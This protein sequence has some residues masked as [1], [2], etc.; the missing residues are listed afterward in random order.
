LSRAVTAR[1]AAL[2]SGLPLGWLWPLSI[3]LDVLHDPAPMKPDSLTLA[4]IRL[5]TGAYHPVLAEAGCPLVL[6]NLWADDLA[7]TARFN[8]V[9]AYLGDVLQFYRWARKSDINPYMSFDRL[10]GFSPAALKSLAV[11]MT[12]RHDGSRLSRSSCERKCTSIKS[13]FAFCFDYFIAKRTLTLLEQRQA[14]KNRDAN[15]HRLDKLFKMRSREGE[16]ESSTLSLSD[17]HAALL[18]HT[19]NPASKKNPFS[20]DV[21][22][23]RNYCMWRLMLATGARRAEIA[24]LELDELSLGL[25]PTVTFRK[26]SE[27]ASS[28]RRD[29]ASLKTQPRVLPLSNSLAELLE[30]YLED[31]RGQLVNTRRPSPAVFLSARDGRRLSAG[32]L[33]TILNMAATAALDGGLDPKVHPH[34]LRTTAMNALSRRARDKDGRVSPEFRDQLIYFAGWGPRSNM[35]LTYTREAISDALGMLLRNPSKKQ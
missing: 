2:G 26:P 33:N 30:T 10:K 32:A 4:L 11:Y 9:K 35:P 23:V 18:E 15:Q 24:L 31:W 6:P 8:T 29:G 1:S 34:R 5:S 3:M 16:L 25:R 20:G 12:T 17:E 13:Y 14:E 27:A 22:R 7:L 28:R 19:L 21:I